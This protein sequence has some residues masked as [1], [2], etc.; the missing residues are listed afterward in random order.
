MCITGTEH[1]VFQYMINHRNSWISEESIMESNSIPLSSYLLSQENVMELIK[2][3]EMN[4]TSGDGGC[5][6][7][8][9]ANDSKDVY[10][11]YGEEYMACKSE[12]RST[13]FPSKTQLLYHE[14]PH[15]TKKPY[16][17]DKC[18]RQFTMKKYLK[19]HEI[20]HTGEKRFTCDECGKQFS[21]SSYLRQHQTM[22][23][24]EKNNKFDECGQQFTQS[25]YLKQ[26]KVINTGEKAFKCDECSKNFSQSAGL[27]Q[28]Q[29]IHT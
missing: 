15:Q 24:G 12:I 28:H 21:R 19:Q 18:D 10:N 1:N 17:C 14:K 20:I 16:K 3:E 4:P 7:S 26:H 11:F 6:S 25:S 9:A 2:I 13:Q 5:C 22:Y 8:S 23:T 27:K 29:L